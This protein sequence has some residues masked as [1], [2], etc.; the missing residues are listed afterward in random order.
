MGTTTMRSLPHEEHR[1]RILAAMVEVA[2]EQGP[3]YATVAHVVARARVSRTAFYE[4]FGSSDDCLDAVFDGAL[5]RAVER[6]SATDDPHARWATRLRTGLYAVLKLIEEEPELAR[7]CVAHALARPATFNR[8]RDTLDQLTRLIDEGRAARRA[9]REPSALAAQVVLG[10][11]LGLVYARLIAHET[12]P[13]LEL[14]NPL[15]SIIVLPYLGA[16]TAERDLTRP[17]RAHPPK[18]RRRAPTQPEGHTASQL[19]NDRRVGGDRSRA[20]SQQR[21]GRRPRRDH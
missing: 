21:R 6:A 9:S 10:G 14:L 2:S 12:S 1:T 17:L 16:A 20:G 3:E 13:I 18:A 4:L 8:R 5:E 7:V 15:M 19:P 11:A